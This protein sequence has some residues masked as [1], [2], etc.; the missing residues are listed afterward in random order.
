MDTRVVLKL[1]ER[2]GLTEAEFN[3]N[4]QRHLDLNDSLPRI[5]SSNDNPLFDWEAEKISLVLEHY[6]DDKVLCS[7]I[8]ALLQLVQKDVARIRA[9]RKKAEKEN[10]KPLRANTF[11]TF[12]V[13]RERE[14]EAV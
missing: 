9:E 4:V 7:I 14:R 1:Y 11:G 3:E 8:C 10:N 2:F 5:R 13:P 12:S 6:K